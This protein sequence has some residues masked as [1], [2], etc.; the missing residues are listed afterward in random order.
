VRGD[1]GGARLKR[2]PG[3]DLDTDP[4]LLPGGASVLRW[5]TLAQRQRFETL[6]ARIQ[7]DSRWAERPT[8]AEAVLA[9]LNDRSYLAQTRGPRR[10]ER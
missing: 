2:N 9:A 4:A 3:G 8:I 7:E 5:T 10:G 1:L 6:V